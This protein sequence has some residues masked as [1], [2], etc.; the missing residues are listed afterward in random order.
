MHKQLIRIVYP[1]DGERT[2]LRTA[3]IAISS[4]SQE[5]PLHCESEEPIAVAYVR[6]FNAK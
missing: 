2:V 4:G 5:N 3:P 1:T 6:H